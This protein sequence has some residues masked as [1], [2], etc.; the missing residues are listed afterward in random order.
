MKAQRVAAVL[1]ELVHEDWAVFLWGAPGIGKS[2]IVRQVA[3]SLSRPVVDLRASLLDPTDLRGIPA[4]VGERAVWCPPAFLPRPGDAP[5]I[6]FLDEI[7]AA[8]PLV[9][10]GLYQLVLDRRVGEYVLPDGW[11][12]VAAGNRRQDKA[13]TFRLSSALVNRFVHLEL[14]PN[15][16]DWQVWAA[17]AGV[18]PEVRSFLRVRP[19]LLNQEPADEG[20]F[21]T[22]RSWEMASDVISRFGSA[23]KA[24][25]VLPGVIGQ[26]PATELLAFIK[27]AVSMEEIEAVVKAPSLAPVPTALDKLWVLITYLTARAKEPAVQACVPLLL[28]RIPADFAVVL[29]RDF[30]KAWPRIIADPKF[31]AYFRAHRSYFA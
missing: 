29:A 25:D 4:I 23:A 7:N 17:G 3:A 2:S 8:P 15:I 16:D 6:L 27:K 24:A 30:L 18:L 14:E 11:K 1:A 20:A 5:G 19:Q 12:I 22:P 31:A 13:V 9:Q 28:P 21:A 26:G 10:A